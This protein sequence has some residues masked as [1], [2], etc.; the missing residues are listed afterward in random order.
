MSDMKYPEH[1]TRAIPGREATLSA[2]P[3]G[4]PKKTSPLP[5]PTQQSGVDPTSQAGQKRLESEI[6]RG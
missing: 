6:P 3:T 4:G 2:A 5:E 1:A